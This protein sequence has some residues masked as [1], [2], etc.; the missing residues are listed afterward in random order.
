MNVNSLI[1]VVVDAD[2][3]SAWLKTKRHADTRM[4]V[5]DTVQSTIRSAGVRLTDDVKARIAAY[6]EMLSSQPPPRQPFLIA[7]GRAGEPARS[8]AFQWREDADAD[9]PFDAADFDQRVAGS[10]RMVEQGDRIGRVRPP[11]E[12]TPGEDV[13]G[14]PIPAD[15]ASFAPIELGPNVRLDDDG[16]TA[17]ALQPG[18]VTFDGKRLDVV[19]AREV[20]VTEKEPVDSIDAPQDV[21][22]RGNVADGARVQAGG[23]VIVA[24]SVEPAE[25]IAR[26]DVIVHFG[27]I[28]RHK[29][30][31]VADNDVAAKF[32]ED[33]DISAGGDVII[34]TNVINSRVLAGRRLMARDAA[35]I[36]GDIRAVQSVEARILGSES[37][38]PTP[39]S[40][41]E[42]G[43]LEARAAR[44]NERIGAGR[45]RLAE[46][47]RALSP[48]QAA[49]RKLS[50]DQQQRVTRL[51]ILAERV[52]SKIHEREALT[53]QW[54]SPAGFRGWIRAA[55]AVFEGVTLTLCDRSVRIDRTMKGPVRFEIRKVR[56][57]SE[58]VAVY[59]PTGSLTVMK[60]KKTNKRAAA[61]AEHG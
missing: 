37:N 21:V 34:A 41:A 17:V 52:E 49:A 53:K 24:G 2:G 28:G 20:I 44:L 40:V 58:L 32:C 30:R 50:A 10:V 59:E 7:Q 16:E 1:E 12:G 43:D 5:P 8:P 45:A 57:A 38:V 11:T 9:R 36:G 23:S 4:I 56:N 26:R 6:L 61:L 3:M 33:A 35:V 25:I 46:L 22:V 47:R 54:T 31:L 29:G 15:G 39:I 51:R 14:R 18:R 27:V 55:E 60:A 48:L 19:R 42:V 13:L